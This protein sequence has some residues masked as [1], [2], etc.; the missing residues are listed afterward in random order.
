MTDPPLASIVGST[1]ATRVLAQASELASELPVGQFVRLLGFALLAGAAAAV[2][3]LVYRWYSDEPIPDGVAVIT[4]VAVVAAWLNTKN[5]LDQAI[6]GDPTPFDPTAAALT[7]AIFATSAI[8]ADAGRRFGD[9]LARTIF[10]VASARSIDAVGRFVRSARRTVPV[11]LPGTIDD[12]EGYDPVA[13]E[14]REALAGETL[15][16]PRRL[17][18]AERRSRLEERLEH[19][20]GLA[21]VVAE[22]D[23]DGTVTALA[24]GSRRAGIGPSLAP[25]QV[26]CAIRADP[27]PEATPGDAVSIWTSGERGETNGGTDTLARVATGELR[28]AVEDV[29]TVAVAPEDGRALEAERYRLATRPGS[30]DAG[31]EFVSVLR[32]VPETVTTIR[33]ADPAAERATTADARLAGTTVGALPV[34]VLAIERA[35]E[36]LA[37]PPD[38]EPL[39][40]DDVA[41]V[42]GLPAAL[43][44]VRAWKPHD[45]EASAGAVDARER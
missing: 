45:A 28:G 23:A 14:T 7:V 38:E 15:S 4:G 1:S 9:D 40:A 39:A 30:P 12:L 3:A 33:V 31:R 43:E 10:A 6:N 44:Q 37:F 42:L 2:L 29:A 13:A 34:A 27:A 11:T 8:A 32:R 22:V 24:A 16:L 21:S 41:Y 20:Y 5:L 26:A 18:P 36:V 35:S 25:G 19:D 17:E